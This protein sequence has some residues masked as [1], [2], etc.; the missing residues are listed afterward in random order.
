MRG[1]DAAKSVGALL[2]QAPAWLHWQIDSIPKELSAIELSNRLNPFL[3]C[4]AELAGIERDYYRQLIRERFGLSRRAIDEEMQ[5]AVLRRQAQLARQ[6][7]QARMTTD[8]RKAAM[9]LLQN[10]AI[11]FRMKRTAQLLGV[12]KE[13][14]NIL[15][16]ALAMISRL[17]E[18]PL[19]VVVKGQSSAGKSY[20]VERV[21]R[22]MPPE[23]LHTW[24]GMSAKALI[25]SKADFKHKVLLIFERKGGDAAQES[26]R[27]LQSE[28]KLVYEVVVKNP[29]TGEFET[30]KYEK[31]GP[32]AF[33]T[34]TTEATIEVDDENRSFSISPDESAKQTARIMKANLRPK[35][36]GAQ[37]Q[38]EEREVRVWHN[39]Q[40]LLT[41]QQIQI[42][43]PKWFEQVRK[44]VPTKPLRIRR[45][46]PRFLALC[47]V[48]AFL[49]QFKRPGKELPD[50]SVQVTVTLADY[51]LARIIARD[52]LRSSL[53]Q[54]P[55][56]TLR[57]IE[58]VRKRDKIH[59]GVT[60]Q[61]IVKDTGMTYGVV[62][63][64]AK[65]ALQAGYLHYH[66]RTLKS[67]EKRIL[68]GTPPKKNNLLPS[69]KRILKL[70]PDI[71]K[72]KYINP[73]SG[74][75]VVLKAAS[76]AKKAI[77]PKKTAGEAK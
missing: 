31:E 37:R 63:K 61:D 69:P 23:A 3:L 39:A 33:V 44:A 50:G 70:Y 38:P 14:R 21:A 25:Y 42:V 59:M 1:K 36:A 22:L 15:L 7:E 75:R 12:S 30:V 8:E 45:D 58:A 60:Y 51:A 57:I 2:N 68:L 62:Y 54:L 52:A 66:Y 16:L 41:E 4:V 43:L 77:K 76:K 20:L 24:S 27:Y 13:G 40:R 47:E 28:K 74:D 5:L 71:E 10:P 46:W 11:L 48:V 53:Y 65:P 67:N 18:D 6:K 56:N 73:L 72:C 9:A 64:W 17:R 19:S 29:Q 49:H 34:T 55:H 35:L 26:V 32:I